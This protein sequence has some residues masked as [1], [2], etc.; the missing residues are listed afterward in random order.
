[1]VLD[2]RPS[3]LHRIDRGVGLWN[4]AQTILKHP[5]LGMSQAFESTAFQTRPAAYRN[6]SGHWLSLSSNSE[7][8]RHR[9][10][11]LTENE[12]LSML[13]SNN[14]QINFSSR[15]NRISMGDQHVMVSCQDGRTFTANVLIGSDGVESAVARTLFPNLRQSNSEFASWGAVVPGYQY[16]AESTNVDVDPKQVQSFLVA[17]KCLHSRF[18]RLLSR[19]SRHSVLVVALPAFLFVTA[20]FG[21]HLYLSLMHRPWIFRYIFDLSN[22]SSS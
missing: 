8:N 10:A 17:N 3:L 20:S 16:Q 4:H 22:L 1:V 11:T 19:P 2:A 6:R 12:L 7:L 14:N 18:S 21:L 5:A 13:A 15:I 9:V